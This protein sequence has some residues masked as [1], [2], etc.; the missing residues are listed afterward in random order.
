MYY[1]SDV[2]DGLK[3]DTYY[4]AGYHE[5]AVSRHLKSLWSCLYPNGAPSDTPSLLLMVDE[6]RGLCETAALDGSEIVDTISEDPY[7]FSN[8]RAFRRA[9]RYLSMVDNHDGHIF[10]LITDTSSRIANF[11]PPLWN[12]DS[13]RLPGLPQAGP[14]QFPPIHIF[15]SIDIYARTFN[16]TA[17]SSPKEV[18]KTERLV[19]FGR[20]G[21]YS[22]FYHAPRTLKK[23]SPD[24]LLHT[25]AKMKLLG[26]EESSRS[27][28]AL[29]RDF[30][31]IAPRLAL[32]IGPYNVEA[33][34]AVA[35]HLAVLVGTDSDRHS[36]KCI[37]PSEPVL[38]QVSAQYTRDVGWSKPLKDLKHYVMTGVVDAGFRGE[39]LTKLTCLMAMDTIQMTTPLEEGYLRFA[40]AV[41]A[42]DFLDALIS[43]IGTST[44][45]AGIMV[46][47]YLTQLI[48]PD[49]VDQVK[50]N[51]NPEKMK[52][53]LNGW[54][55]FN[56]FVRVEVEVSVPILIHAWNRGAAIMCKTG[57]EGIDYLIP[58]MLEEED[59]DKDVT[60]GPLF[61]DF[62]PR[63][64]LKA[65]R[66]RLTVF[67]INSKNYASGKDQEDAAWGTK[68]SK[69]NFRRSVDLLR[70]QRAMKTSG[71]KQ[72]VHKFVLQ[73]VGKPRDDVEENAEE[74][75]EADNRPGY[76]MAQSEDDGTTS[77]RGV[78]RTKHAKDRTPEDLA[79]E[80]DDEL[81]K[82]SITDNVFLSLVQDF[83]PKL[84][85]EK[86]VTLGE[87][88]PHPSPEYS[89]ARAAQP[90]L[91]TPEPKN[92][93]V[94][95][96]KGIG[97]STYRLLRDDR[98]AAEQRENPNFSE[99]AHIMKYLSELP[100]VKQYLADL[101]QVRLPY[102]DDQR[103][104]M[105]RIAGEGTILD[106]S[107]IG[108]LQELPLVYGNGEWCLP[109]WNDVIQGYQSQLRAELPT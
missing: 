66:R 1:Y 80:N 74:A 82:K 62:W 24:T 23:R 22:V 39:L 73:A 91:K 45:P 26:P 85:R 6:A 21:W 48:S 64:D 31:S 99:R 109:Q 107:Q 47:E 77:M 89:H 41:R 20:A 97:P 42:K 53:F 36:L 103:Q 4:K 105:K 104:L 44:S 8:F 32:T 67:A 75:E 70:Q 28:K 17:L 71:E 79:D 78:K 37:Y 65:G 69:K 35:S 33:A 72:D 84:R 7:L 87:L 61:G 100:A 52:A 60:F 59:T 10:S 2:L 88:V 90:P 56:H 86:F 55:F 12:D 49:G 29:L 68:L 51:V 5:D 9:L 101:S 96:L 43:P 27:K 34:E 16:C 58:V 106:S 50:L 94:I 3:A 11:Q 13:M 38:A 63:E 25:I 54:V 30:A 108:L 83:G 98:F 81:D 92:Q 18:T 57:T 95:I 93:V 15:S 76:M 14:G 46:S 19:K 102:I 40:R